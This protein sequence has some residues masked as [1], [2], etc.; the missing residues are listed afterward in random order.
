MCVS[1]C[2]KLPTYVEEQARPNVATVKHQQTDCH[3]G[4]TI[5]K[6]TLSLRTPAPESQ[7]IS[8]EASMRVLSRGLLLGGVSMN[9]SYIHVNLSVSLYNT[10]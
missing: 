1:V 2:Q 10:V 9:E 7:H 6:P 5:A 8:V 4:L 3:H